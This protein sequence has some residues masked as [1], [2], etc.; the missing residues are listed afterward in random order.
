MLTRL[1]APVGRADLLPP[2]VAGRLG[3]VLFGGDPAAGAVAQVDRV[4]LGV[5]YEAGTR[6]RVQVQIY[7]SPWRAEADVFADPPRTENENID[8]VVWGR[9]TLPVP[10]AMVPIE[11][12]V[13]RTLSWPTLAT[14]DAGLPAGL[15][16]D[17]LEQA[18]RLALGRSLDDGLS[19]APTDDDRVAR[20]G[21][22]MDRAGVTSVPQ[23]LDAVSGEAAIAGYSLRFADVAPAAGAE[24]LPFTAAVVIERFSN[25]VATWR[26]VLRRARDAQRSVRTGG[27]STAD[28]KGIVPR[29]RVPVLLFTPQ[30]LFTD[31]QW[32]G[33]QAGATAGEQRQQRED[34][35]SAWLADAGIV[36]AS[37]ADP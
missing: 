18:R 9:L 13:G 33:A 20:I 32:P 29:E 7:E 26:G 36:L 34:T 10:T 6:A 23:L 16:A 30:S 4:Q 27:Q 28:F 5:P 8:A 31:A 3:Q 24:T 12:V 37:V 25:D 17:Q 21:G 22:L 35:A 15:A 14:L 1:A 2:R 11:K 19:A